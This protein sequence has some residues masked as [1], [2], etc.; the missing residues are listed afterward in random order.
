MNPKIEK[1]LLQQIDFYEFGKVVE[2]Y[3]IVF[4][5]MSEKAKDW[6]EVLAEEKFKNSWSPKW[7]CPEDPPWAFEKNGNK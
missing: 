6:C 5:D 1:E 3:G 4:N 2:K 7:E